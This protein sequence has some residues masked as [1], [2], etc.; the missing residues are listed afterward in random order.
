MDGIVSDVRAITSVFRGPAGPN[1]THGVEARAAR[2]A[3]SVAVGI[4]IVG[5]TGDGVVENSETPRTRTI[6]ASL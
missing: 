1:R 6:F 5:A 3:H 4:R 2:G